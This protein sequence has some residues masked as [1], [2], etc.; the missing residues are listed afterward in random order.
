MQ[1]IKYD[2]LSDTEKCNIIKK[3]YTK[4]KLSFAGIAKQ[5]GTYSNKVRRDANK[6]N[7]KIRDRSQ[8]QKNALQT[9]AVKHPTQGKNRSEEEKQKISMSQHES[10]KNQDENT[11]KQRSKKAKL[12]W[13]SMS[14]SQKENLRV[15]AH[16]AIRETSKTGSKLEKFLLTKLIEKGYK[17]EFHKEQIL[18]NTKLH[19]DLFIAKLNTAIEIDGPSHYIS[20]WGDESLARNQKYD[21]KKNGLII[22]KGMRLIRIKQLNDYSNARAEIVFSKLDNLLQQIKQNSLDSSQKILYIED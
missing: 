3:L 12:R 8:A 22:G 19:I 2:Q 16:Q 18:S 1:N 7:I 11:K 10:W 14:E 15:A 4:E 13:Q 6:F 20:V 9:G 5:L 17:P 21:Q